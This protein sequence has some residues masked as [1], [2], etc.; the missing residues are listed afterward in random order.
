MRELATRSA[1]VVGER[2][3]P[4]IAVARPAAWPHPQDRL[5]AGD[6]PWEPAGDVQVCCRAERGHLVAGLRGVLDAASAPA[7]REH[8]LRVV[9]QCAGRLIVDLSAVSHADAGGLSVLVGTERRARLLGGFLRL[10]APSAGVAAS[11]SA[12]GLDRQLAMFPTVEAAISVPA[13]V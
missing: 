6:H 7:L 12:T 4:V 3:S 11:L 9:H 10:A 5:R 1:L 8:L 13:P 2:A